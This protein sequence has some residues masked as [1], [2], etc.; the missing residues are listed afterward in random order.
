MKLK[1]AFGLSAT[2]LFSFTCF[3]QSDLTIK[4]KTSMKIPGMPA[5]PMG[6]GNPFPDRKSTDYIKGANRRTDSENE[7]RTKMGKKQRVTYTSIT[8]CAKQRRISYNTKKKSYYAES[9]AGASSSDVKNAR[10]GGKIIMTGVVTDTGERAKLFGFDAKHLKQTLTIEPGPN[11]CQKETMKMDIDGWYVDMPQYSCPLR[12]KPREFQMDSACFDDVEYRMKGEITGFAVKEIK[13]MS[14]QGM[15][16]NMEEEVV[17]IL[18]TPLADSLFEPPVGFKAANTLKE[19]EDDSEGDAA[20]TFDPTID[21]PQTTTTNTTL[22]IP[23][24]G[25]EKT[26]PV[27]KRPGVI[28]IGIVKPAV[29][30]ADK[31]S[32]ES[33]SDVA[34]AIAGVFEE[35]LIGPKIE[36][37]RLASESEAAGT[38]CDYTIKG[39]LS[40]KHAGGGMLG[41]MLSPPKMGA[42][43][44]PTKRT[45]AENELTSAIASSSKMKDEFTFDFQLLGPGG[46]VAFQ[47]SGKAKL[48][49]PGEDVLSPPIRET[50]SAILMKIGR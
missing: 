21:A 43:P 24:A 35:K 25:V 40:Q 13:T 20:G 32:A 39:T 19:V 36:V 1:L 34:D 15:T 16:M 6:M 28:R 46:A 2:I 5:M 11:A 17:E 12:R 42:Q 3:G 33:A 7:E 4:K 37:V 48:G 18:T 31:D 38:E 26:G 47:K 14:M 45:P 50:A 23:K 30:L 22:A 9:M 44:D 8:Q 29:M 49:F 27:A 10:S 41:M